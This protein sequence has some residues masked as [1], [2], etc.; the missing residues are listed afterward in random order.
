MAQLAQLLQAP[1][2]EQPFAAV[3]HHIPTDLRFQLAR[4]LTEAWA[5]WVRLPPDARWRMVVSTM[6]RCCMTNMGADVRR[7]WNFTR[8]CRGDLLQCTGL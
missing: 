5:R 7:A 6:Q 3:C 8:R 1:Q 4:V 2:A